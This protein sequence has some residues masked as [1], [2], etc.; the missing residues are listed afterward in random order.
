MDIVFS[1]I[2]PIKLVRQFDGFGTLYYRGVYLCDTLENNEF[3]IKPGCYPLKWTYSPKFKAF[4]FE[5]GDVPGRTRLLIHEGNYVGDSK[6]CVLVGVRAGSVLH[7]S[8][9][10]LRRINRVI[11]DISIP[12]IEISNNYEF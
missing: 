2:E 9:V 12:L 7:Y 4:R 5:V 11:H 6:G 3:L 8:V 1:E 10:T